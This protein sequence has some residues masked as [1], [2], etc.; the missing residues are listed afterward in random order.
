VA[1]TVDPVLAHEGELVRLIGAD[2]PLFTQNT[3][4]QT[5]VFTP[6]RAALFGRLTGG[7][8]AFRRF[9]TPRGVRCQA[10]NAGSR[11]KARAWLHLIRVLKRDDRVSLELG[12]VHAAGDYD[13]L[14]AIGRFGA[15]PGKVRALAGIELGRR[16]GD[17]GF[18]VVVLLGF[19]ERL[20]E[21]VEGAR[22]AIRHGE[23]ERAEGGAV[24]WEGGGHGNHGGPDGGVGRT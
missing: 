13:L 12:V 17:D 19:R 20:E 23:A 22:L 7:G 2:A 9:R 16:L 24:E 11:R 4:G 8:G 18:A 21:R 3:A 5:L 6:V 14:D 10:P 15:D 1:A